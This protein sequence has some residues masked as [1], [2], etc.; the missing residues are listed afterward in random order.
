MLTPLKIESFAMTRS[1]GAL[2]DLGLPA[3]DR[4][5]LRSM[6][7]VGRPIKRGEALYRV[8]GPFN[9]IYEVHAGYFKTSAALGDGRRQIVGFQVVGDLLGWDGIGTGQHTVDA[10]AKVDSLVWVVPFS[11]LA[12]MSEQSAEFQHALH[13]VMASEI[14]ANRAMMFSLGRRGADARVAAFLLNL[15][16]RLQARGFSPL[17]VNLPMSRREIANY[18][19]LRFETVSRVFSRLLEAGTIDLS[20]RDVRF[21]DIDALRRIA[22]DVPAIDR[23]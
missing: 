15:T 1:S 17:A 7:I 18:V 8:G 21:R 19:G 2:F 6:A 16:E 13:R 20:H 22:S 14:S 9:A 12:T 10:V 11:S 3:L 23:C 5:R 4:E